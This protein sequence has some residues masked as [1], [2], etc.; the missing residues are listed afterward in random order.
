MRSACRLALVVLLLHAGA[1]KLA[2]E[3]LRLVLDSAYA[4][5]HVPILTALVHGHFA[6]AGIEP[7]IEPGLGVN[8]VAVLVG[9]RAFDIGHLSTPAAAIAISRGSPIRMVAIY[10]P[11]T[12]LGLVG[13]KGQVRLD[14]PKSVEGLRLGLTPGTADSL[15]LNLFRRANGIG[16]SAVTVIPTGR[17]AKL[18]DLIAGRLDVVI[19]DT[20]LLRAGLLAA[21]QEP[22]VLEVADYDVPLQG[23]GF[24]ASQALLG[25]NSELARRALGALR[26]GFADA[27]A[28]P[29][30]ACRD[31]RTRFALAESDEICTQA[32]TIFLASLA[33]PTAGWGQ[34]SAEAWQRMIE[35]MRAVGEI[36]GTKPPS[37]YYTNA[38]IP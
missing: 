20:I 30:G 33:P 38:V 24:V 34:Q 8:M 23:Y 13:L 12:A 36:R 21:G 6:R 5:H 4:P 31:T 16:V 27:A 18:T 37:F 7:V 26:A 19:G 3:P 10:Q 22:E 35:A 9:Q 14:R 11:R 28:D 17:D 25:E 1:A 32:V 2:A 15:A 29:A